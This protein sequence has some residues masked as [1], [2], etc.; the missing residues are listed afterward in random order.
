[1]SSSASAQ[2]T[3]TFELRWSGEPGEGLG[4]AAGSLTQVTANIAAVVSQAESRQVIALEV[5]SAATTWSLAFMPASGTLLPGTYSGAVGQPNEDSEPVLA[6]NH[7]GLE[8]ATSIATFEI[9]EVA[10]SG[11]SLD[12]FAADLQIGCG[13]GAEP[14][15][16][17]QL[18]AGIRYNSTVPF[19][20]DRTI[21]GTVDYVTGPAAE[22]RICANAVL[23]PAR[24]RC[25]TADDYGRYEIQDLAAD[26]YYVS[27]SA[28]EGLLSCFDSQPSCAS[29]TYLSF[30]QP[31]FVNTG[32]DAVLSVGCAGEQATIVGTSQADTLTG[33]D[34]RDVIVGLGGDDVINGGGGDDILCGGSGDDSIA[35]GAGNDLING[36]EGDDGLWGQ[37]GDDVISG[38]LGHD[39]LRGGS[40]DDYLSGGPGND[41]LNAGRDDDEA[42]GDS[43]DDLVRGGTGDDLVDGGEGDDY[44]NGNGGTDEVYGG[45]GH[46]TFVA[47]GPRID[48]IFGGDGND[49]IKGLG[50]ADTIYAGNGNDMVFGGKQ[51][52]TVDG[53]AGTDDCNGGGGDYDSYTRCESV[54]NFELQAG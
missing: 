33:T 21:T 11:T 1:M 50:G 35:A 30:S 18:L 23:S 51:S 17:A 40:D 25:A 5:E 38:A 53:G 6:V 8:C 32:I 48:T 28:P 41:D 19:D 26:D 24:T 2:T 3:D 14:G 12:A 45:P 37:A 20:T 54:T 42:H 9:L 36:G 22:A 16:V 4:G 7:D 44:V 34:G 52:D 10:T 49:T 47:G 27:F 46:D 39:K 15:G 43:G 29:A 31:I 13:A